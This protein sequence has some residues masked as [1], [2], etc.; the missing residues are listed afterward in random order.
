MPGFRVEVDHDH[1]DLS[2]QP[3]N[4]VFDLGETASDVRGAT[5]P[6]KVADTLWSC[7]NKS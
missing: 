7:E 3:A 2:Q 5:G 6:E 4:N 1:I